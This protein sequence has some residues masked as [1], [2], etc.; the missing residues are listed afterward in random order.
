[1]KKLLAIGG[2]I[3]VIFVL[4]LVLNNQSNKGK[5]KDNPYGTDNLQQ[6]TIDLIG[7]ENYNNIILPEEL[8]EKVKSGEPVVAY[9]FSP[10][11]SYCKEM[12]PVLMP[13]AKQMD[14]EVDQYNLLEFGNEA[15]PYHVEAT[16]TLIYFNN[17]EEVGR[18]V[19]GQPAE[20]IEAFF[21]AIKDEVE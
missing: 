4:I 14:V 15:S 21:K 17:G 11:C 1:M 18:M 6:A 13:I 3:V 7:D 8:S 9:F 5:L 12:T 10:L 16:P 19:G 2:I 20:N